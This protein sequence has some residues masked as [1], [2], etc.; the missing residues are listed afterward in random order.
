VSARHKAGVAVR[1]PRMLRMRADKTVDEA[2]TLSTLK[3]LLA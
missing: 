3:G 2:D 1:F